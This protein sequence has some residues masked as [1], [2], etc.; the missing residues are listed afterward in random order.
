MQDERRNTLIE[1]IEWIWIVSAGLIFLSPFIIAD[2]IYKER[3]D[4][5]LPTCIMIL[6]DMF[7]IVLPLFKIIDTNKDRY[8]IKRRD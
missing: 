8:N 4:L 1:E 2:M 7:I 5:I 6:F 3:Y